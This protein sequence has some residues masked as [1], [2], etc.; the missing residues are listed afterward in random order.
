MGYL[1]TL[2]L[3]LFATLI[4]SHFSL[5]LGIPAVIGELLAGIL[6]GP[7]CSTGSI[8]AP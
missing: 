6:F 5:Q 8:P 2:A 4:L 3:I 7:A 1:G